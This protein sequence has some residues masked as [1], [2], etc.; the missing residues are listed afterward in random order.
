MCY[1]HCVLR[2]LNVLVEATFM[3]ISSVW[4]AVLTLLVHRNSLREYRGPMDQEVLEGKHHQPSS[5]LP[6]LV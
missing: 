2:L 1:C 3:V 6:D 5:S 4:S